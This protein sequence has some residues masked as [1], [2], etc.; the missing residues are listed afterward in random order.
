VK[1]GP[2]MSEP[3]KIGLV[4]SERAKSERMKPKRSR[5][6]RARGNATF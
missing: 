3:A 1:I 6:G 5:P 4:K 2:V